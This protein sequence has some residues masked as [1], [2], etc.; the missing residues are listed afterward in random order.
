M[1]H[2]GFSGSCQRIA[3]GIMAP[4]GKNWND[5]TST[6]TFYLDGCEG[7]VERSRVAIRSTEPRQ[8]ASGSMELR[9]ISVVRG[10]RTLRGQLISVGV[11]ATGVRR[12]VRTQRQLKRTQKRCYSNI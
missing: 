12:S 9:R 1:Q 8:R 5:H 6:Y 2:R 10:D 11:E 4:G 7:N 3:R